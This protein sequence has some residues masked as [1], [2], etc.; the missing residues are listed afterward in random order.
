MWISKWLVC[1]INIQLTFENHESTVQMFH[2]YYESFA[3][4]IYPFWRY[5]PPRRRAQLGAGFTSLTTKVTAVVITNALW[6]PTNRASNSLCALEFCSPLIAYK[7]TSWIR[8]CSVTASLRISCLS[9][10]LS[11][12]GYLYQQKNKTTD[13]RATMWC[14]QSIM[15]SFPAWT[16]AR[17]NQYKISRAHEP[18]GCE[19][20]P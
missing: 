14:V 8:W 10:C 1:S 2:L 16:L 19:C 3:A 20:L 13:I 4:H 5:S 17:F 7:Q 18:I 12:N 6:I 11:R 9:A 15:V